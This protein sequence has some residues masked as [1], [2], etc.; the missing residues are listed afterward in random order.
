[1]NTPDDYRP[2]PGRQPKISQAVVDSIIAMIA[3]GNFR[4]H[5][6]KR[7]GIHLATLKRWLKMGREQAEQ[8]PDSL[9][10][11]LRDRLLVAETAVESALVKTIVVVGMTEDVKHAEWYL[12]RKYPQ[13]W[14]RYRGELKQLEKEVAELKKMIQGQ[15]NEAERL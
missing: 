9:Y 14:G 6:C 5:A 13:R 12:E 10:V 1:M 4:S 7:V 3:A 15:A 2:R 11:Q 8:Y